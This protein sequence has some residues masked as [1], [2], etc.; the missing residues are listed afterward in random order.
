M[1]WV[2]QAWLVYRLTGSAIWLGFIGFAGQ[3][4]VFLFAPVG[5]AVADQHNRRLILVAT[6]SVSMV[7]AFL[8]AALTLSHQI[9]VWQVFLFAALQGLV[10]AFDIPARQAFLMDMVGREDLLNAIALNSSMFNGAR[11]IGPAM[12]GLLVSG[13]GEGWCFFANAVSYL[14]VIAGLLLMKIHSLA[15]RPRSGST[16]DSIREGF[17]YVGRTGPIRDL[18]ILLGLI[19][20]LGIPY[21]VLMPIFADRILHGGADGL[22]LLM[23]S[24]GVGALLAALILAARRGV[25]GLG[26]WVA[27][28]SVAFGVSLILFSLSRSF[29]LSAALLM[30]VGFAM[31]TEMAA[32][33]TLIQAMTPDSLRGRVMAVYSMMFMGMA[34][35]GALL[36][37]TM[38][39][40]LGAPATVA[41]GGAVCVLAGL[42]FGYRLPAFR[43]ERRLVILDQQLPGEGRLADLRDTENPILEKDHKEEQGL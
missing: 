22:G 4:P 34:P 27:V 7:L 13:L 36:S 32:S 35:V 6:Q 37:G 26:R 43:R 14:A 18:L 41:L 3:I 28:S 12:G 25:Q 29:W 11:M 9:Q 31:M 24:S 42:G 33:N 21:V 5:G 2:A 20:L 40:H 16:L 10:N 1:Q 39:H 38:A 17:W 19:S 30:P 15:Y 8:L 23:G